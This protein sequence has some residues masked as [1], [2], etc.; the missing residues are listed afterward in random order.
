MNKET[1][2]GAF[3]LIVMPMLDYWDNKYGPAAYIREQSVYTAHVCKNT[4]QECW[5]H[6]NK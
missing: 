6:N 1:V 5:Y 4:P 2:M 3:V